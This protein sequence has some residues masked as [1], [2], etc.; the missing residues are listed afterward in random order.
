MRKLNDS[1]R[2]L[3]KGDVV[4]RQMGHLPDNKVDKAYDKSLRLDDRRKHME[5]YGTI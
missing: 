2:H 5:R 4:R 1:S 3:L